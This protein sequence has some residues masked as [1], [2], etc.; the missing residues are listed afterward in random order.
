MES[1]PDRVSNAG[2]DAP[3]IHQDWC[4]LLIDAEDTI[5]DARRCYRDDPM[6]QLKLRQSAIDEA[7]ET[8]QQARAALP[9]AEV[10]RH[11]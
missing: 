10:P 1:T 8:L 9:G 6:V 4:S 7:I 3:E 5:R 11:G 2:P